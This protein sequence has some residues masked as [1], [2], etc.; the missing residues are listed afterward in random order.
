MISSEL[1]E[2]LRIGDRILV[3]REG[4]L[5]AEYRA[6]DATEETIMAAATG[7]LRR[8]RR[9]DAPRV[10][11]GASPPAPAARRPARGGS[12]SGVFRIRE[13]GIL[14]VLVVFVAVT[15]AIQPRS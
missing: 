6:R 5:T 10:T 14:A 1:P 15:T 11:S 12:P 2:V 3:M 8:A 13:S 9:H 7:Q 4:R